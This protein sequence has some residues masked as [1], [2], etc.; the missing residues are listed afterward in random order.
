MTFSVSF[1]TLLS[2]ANK[3]SFTYKLDTDQQKALIDILKCGNYKPIAREYTLFAAETENC[4]IALYTS[5]KCLVQ[6]QGA[7]DFVTFVLEPQIL[8]SA[9]LS[10]DIELSCSTDTE[11]LGGAIIRAGDLVIDGSVRGKLERLGAAL[12]S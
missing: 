8:Q 10:R 5:G 6:G 1:A 3:T 4:N 2:M 7:H 11:L 9:G 12:N